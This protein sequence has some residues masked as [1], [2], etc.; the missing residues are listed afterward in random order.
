MYPSRHTVGFL[1]AFALLCAPSLAH[2]QQEDR[3]AAR[4][5]FDAG[6]EL[7]A[8]GRY[9]DACPKFE[10][11][12]HL[13]PGAGI[14]LNLGDCYEHTGRLARAW[15]TFG[16]AAARASRDSRPQE[17]D[18]ARRR[19]G[20]LEPRLAQVV[21]QVTGSAAGLHLT[22]QDAEIPSSQWG[23]ALRFDPGSLTVAASAPGRKSW[24]QTVDA[25]QPGSTTTI[26]VP[27]LEQQDAAGPPAAATAPLAAAPASGAAPTSQA[28]PASASAEPAPPP[29]SA[30]EP[31][32]HQ[33]MWALVT[34]GTGA[35]AV[36]VG[37]VM[38]LVARSQFNSAES[39]GVG[40]HAASEGAVNLGNVA[41]GVMIGGA[42]IAGVGVTLWFTAP[43]A[44]TQVGFD[45]RQVL[46]S[47]S[48]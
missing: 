26:V 34:G 6:K 22:I 25:S 37:G 2:G 44:S 41:T 8:A 36:I 46:F 9:A 11:A 15:R 17:A 32:N 16:D 30:P 5:L 40:R 39:E 24:S 3:A 45:G 23:T 35:A 1:V 31:S 48:F 18:E 14:L 20:L 29:G 42:V 43:R 7:V 27:E 19:Q 28:G 47:R 21:V 38:G 33:R 13:F 12:A 10:Q 4:P